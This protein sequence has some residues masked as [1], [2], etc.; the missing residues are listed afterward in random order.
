MEEY[1]NYKVMNVIPIWNIKR[2]TLQDKSFP[3]SA[4]DRIH[5]EHILDVVKSRKQNGYMLTFDNNQFE[6]IKR[7]DDN[8][9]VITFL[10]NQSE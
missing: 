5:Y 7:Y 3:M 4:Q 1:E 2:I 10:E 9:T 6:Y 8:I